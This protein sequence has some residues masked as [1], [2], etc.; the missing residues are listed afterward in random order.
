VVE[1]DIVFVGA[2]RLDLISTRAF[3]L[4]PFENLVIDPPEIWT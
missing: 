3:T 4:P 1:P 2:D